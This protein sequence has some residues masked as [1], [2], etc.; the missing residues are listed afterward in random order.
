MIKKNN[1]NNKNNQ[2]VSEEKKRISKLS[3]NKNRSK[4]KNESQNKTPNYLLVKKLLKNS[5]GNAEEEKNNKNFQESIN[6]KKET[7]IFSFIHT[8]NKITK[9]KLI[10][11][12][13]IDNAFVN[14][15]NKKECLSKNKS[16]SNFQIHNQ[17]ENFKEDLNTNIKQNINYNIEM[18]PVKKIGFIF[19]GLNSNE[20]KN[21]CIKLCNHKSCRNTKN[22]NFNNNEIIVNSKY[23]RN[24]NKKNHK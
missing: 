24:E 19:K 23:L 12:N 15:I 2:Q 16:N 6:A 13:K 11:E 8:D 9:L 21:S 14:E 17:N 10:Y 7:Q 4:P 3:H 1:S 22:I 20:K 18:S 5:Q